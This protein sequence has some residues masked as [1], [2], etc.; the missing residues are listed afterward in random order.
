MAVRGEEVPARR[1][2]A[3][4]P[5]H[6]PPTLVERLRAVHLQMMDAVLGG[7]GLGRVAELAA[8]AAAGPV[9][10]VV[11]RLGA[12]AVAPEGAVPEAEVAAV[13][14]YVADRLKDRPVAAPEVLAAEVPVQSGDDVIGAVVLL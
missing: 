2:D 4:R 13:R 12:A 11:P 5:A 7:E 9:A 1:G 10:I 14:R 3:V 8:E 6:E